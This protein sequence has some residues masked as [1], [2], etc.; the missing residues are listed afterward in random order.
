M[1][2]IKD[3]VKNME[4]QILIMNATFMEKKHDDQQWKK[5]CAMI[6]KWEMLQRIKKN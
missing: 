4:D 3:N 1:E 6:I 2:G 5:M